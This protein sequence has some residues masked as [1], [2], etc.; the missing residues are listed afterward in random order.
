MSR[1]VGEYLDD[2]IDMFQKIL[3]FTNDGEDA[4]Q[5]DEKTQYAVVRAFEII[6][7][8]TKRLPMEFRAAHPQ[9]NW[10]ILAGFRDFLAHNYEELRVDFIWNAVEDVPV[11]QQL[12]IDLRNDL[13][14]DYPLR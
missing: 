9:V 8:I 10:R 2:L 7:K 5:G 6:G 11:I 14:A 3:T 1:S 4:F 13:S 12:L